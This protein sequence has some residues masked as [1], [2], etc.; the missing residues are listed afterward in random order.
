MAFM[1]LVDD[2]FFFSF[3]L[4]SYLGCFDIEPSKKIPVQRSYLGCFDIKLVFRA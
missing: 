2:I 4:T 1:L 3:Y